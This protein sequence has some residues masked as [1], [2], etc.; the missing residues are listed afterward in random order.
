M[1]KK[2]FNSGFIALS[3]VLILSAVFLFIT[4]SLATRAVTSSNVSVSLSEREVVRQAAY[5]CL[6]YARMELIRSLDYAGDEVILIGD[7][8]CE[9]LPVT[10]EGNSDRL[11]KV[12]SVVGPYSFRLEERISEIS[13]VMTITETR[14]VNDF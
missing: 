3:S 13:P 14:R 1:I 10:G 6:D 11:V 9:I 8:V 7:T 2:K 4:V 5:G 12:E